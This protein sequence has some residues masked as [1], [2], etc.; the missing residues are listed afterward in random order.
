MG[1]VA[2]VSTF[3][4]TEEGVIYHPISE[5]AIKVDHDVEEARERLANI[6]KN[7]QKSRAKNTG[8]SRL[9]P[10]GGT[11]GDNVN[12]AEQVVPAEEL[13]SDSGNEYSEDEATEGDDRV[14][15]TPSPTTTPTTNLLAI[16]QIERQLRTGTNQDL[17]GREQDKMNRLLARSAA[18]A[19]KSGGNKAL[20]SQYVHKPQAA[21]NA[22][23]RAIVHHTGS[24]Y[25]MAGSKQFQKGVRVKGVI[26]RHSKQGAVLQAKRTSARNF[27]VARE[28]ARGQRAEGQGRSQGKSKK[29]GAQAQA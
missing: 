26:S 22:A 16:R 3:Y 15:A 29:K 7:R 18:H 9:I 6:L 5:E 12:V 2:N 23:K 25:V 13:Y 4:A 17:A 11:N 1:R 19:S 21:D 28:D 10:V 14:A 27:V 20:P 24:H 8:R